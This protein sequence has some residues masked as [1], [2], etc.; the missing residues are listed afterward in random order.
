[1]AGSYELRL[2]TDTGKYLQ[3]LDR[4]MSLQASRTVSRIGHLELRV[5]WTFNDRLIRPDRMIQVW[6]AAPG[7]P[8]KLFRPYFIRRWRFQTGAEGAE[9]VYIA[10]VCP[11]DLLRRRIVAHYA[12]ETNA[13]ASGEEADD[14][15]KRIVTD[16][17]TD[18]SNPSPT[19]GTRVWSAFSVAGDRTAGPQLTKDFAWQPLLTTAGGGLLPTLAEAA[20]EAG[21]E[22]FFDVAVD[23]VSPSSISFQFRTY[24]DQPGQDMTGK[25]RFDKERSMDDP[26]LEFDHTHEANYI[27]AGGQGVEDEREIQ[28]VYSAWGSTYGYGGYNRSAWNRCEAFEYCT[29]QSAANGVREAAR[30]RLKEGR[31]TKRF[32]GQPKDTA[33]TR[34]GLHWNWGDKVRARYRNEEFDCIIRAV[35]LGVYQGVETISARMEYEA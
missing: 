21:T 8:M 15:M 34:F 10:G 25:T 26:Y 1:V 14:L 3:T 18:G 33:A 4:F 24:T 16:A 11:N 5:P 28:Q 30:A 20:K 13:T 22:V 27:Y 6:R 17:V 35:V 19:A 29:N 7:G 31:P 12:N 23:S 2:T 32:S 9:Y